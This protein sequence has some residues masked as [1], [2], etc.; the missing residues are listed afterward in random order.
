MLV[1]GHV[2]KTGEISEVIFMKEIT[3]TKEKGEGGRCVTL[4]RV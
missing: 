3:Q 4:G 1:R 2:E